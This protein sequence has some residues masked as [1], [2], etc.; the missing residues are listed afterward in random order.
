MIEALR[1]SGGVQ[2]HAAK[3]IGM[4]IRT[5]VTKLKR[6]GI[7]AKDFSGGV[8]ISLAGGTATPTR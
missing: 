3:L 1:A 7:S 8:V 4:P 6:Y 2:M 5:F